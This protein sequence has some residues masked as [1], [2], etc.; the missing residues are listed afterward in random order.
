MKNED[1]RMHDT[2]QYLHGQVLATQALI[3]ALARITTDRDSFQAEALRQLELLR[4]ALLPEPVSEVQI[5]AVDATQRWLQA[6]G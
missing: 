5:A 6:L 4:E 3:V 1:K 2:P